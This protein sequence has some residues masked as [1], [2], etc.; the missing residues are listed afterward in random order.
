[1]VYL[2]RSCHCTVKYTTNAHTARTWAND[3]RFRKTDVIGDDI[4]EVQLVK[5]KIKLDLPVHL[6]VY[7]LQMAK[8]HMLKFHYDVFDK[9]VPRQHYQLLCGNTDSVYYALSEPTLEAAIRPSLLS[10][11]RS[12]LFDYC[13]DRW[14]NVDTGSGFF[15]RECCDK[16]KTFDKRTLGNENW[17]NGHLSHCPL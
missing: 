8:L 5:A 17:S 9:Y 1:M 3:R 2:S 11:Y 12:E 7:L 13:D 16:H 15:L 10:A 6:G 4:Y 14:N